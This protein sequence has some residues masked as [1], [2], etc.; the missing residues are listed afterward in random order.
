VKRLS[1]VIT[2][3]L[4][5]TGAAALGAAQGAPSGDVT[6][7]QAPKVPPVERLGPNRL[8]LGAVRVD[9]AAREVSVSGHVNDVMVLEWVANTQ[10]GFKAYES[11]ITADTDAITFNAALLMIGLDKSRSRVPEMHFDPKPPLG[12]RVEV[13]VE[14]GAGANQKRIPIEQLLFDKRTNQPL[15]SDPWVYTGSTFLPGTNAYQAQ[16][17]GV[18]IGFVHSPAPV[19]EN[20]GTGAVGAFGSVVLN[21]ELVPPGT[22]VTLIVRALPQEKSSNR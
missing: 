6:G 20:G 22:P 7:Y 12:D 3:A 16:V 15:P 8:R 10:G 5:L 1:V 2:T 9:T 4:L 13:L 21:K 11:A 18:L 17:D 19:I 14:W